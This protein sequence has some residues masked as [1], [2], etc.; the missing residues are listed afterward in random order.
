[1]RENQVPKSRKQPKKKNGKQDNAYLKVFIAIVIF[2][3]ALTLL[4]RSTNIVENVLVSYDTDSTI[5]YKVDLFPNEYIKSEYMEEGK[6][7]ISNLVSNIRTDFKYS[8][9]SSKKLESE[10]VYDIYAKA[11]VNHNSTGKELWTEEIKLVDSVKA[12]VTDKN[13][14]NI[15]NSVV[16]PYNQLN[17]KVK[18]FKSQHNIPITSYVDLKLVLKDSKTK[19]EIATTGLSMN[20]FEDVFEVTELQTGKD[21]I[22]ITENHEPNKV[23]VLVESFVALISFIYAAYLIYSII[24]SSIV[25]K[26]YYA[27]AVYKILRNYGDIVAEIVKPVDLGNLKVIDVKNFDQMLDVEEEL[28]IPIMFYE[29][30]KNE[31]GWFVLVHNDMAYRYILRDKLKF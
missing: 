5:D 23:I 16:L 3:I 13:T 17:T 8:I 12:T 15:S 14:I 20:L 28:R 1:M 22:N 29:T 27:K 21:T 10:Y 30:I 7:Y 26:S 18:S 31:E 4:S 9:K 2:L 6:T 25:R 19:Q 11:Y 24:N